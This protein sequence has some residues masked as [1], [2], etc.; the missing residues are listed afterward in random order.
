MY[1]KPRAASVTIIVPSCVV[2]LKCFCVILSVQGHT[3]AIAATTTALPTRNMLERLVR[4]K[5]IQAIFRR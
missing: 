1:L 4:R 3:Y 5:A 2:S